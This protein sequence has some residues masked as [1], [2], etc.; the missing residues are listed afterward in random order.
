M[1][2]RAGLDAVAKR[3]KSHH[4]PR[5]ELNLGRPARSLVSILV[6]AGKCHINLTAFTTA[7]KFICAIHRSL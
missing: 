5:R 4:Y 6:L 2:P 3:R 7:F 1:I